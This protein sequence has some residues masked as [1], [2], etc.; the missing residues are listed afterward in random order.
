MIWAVQSPWST[1]PRS[2]WYAVLIVRA[3]SCSPVMR[4][5]SH[6]ASHF[7][8]ASWV[9][10]V[11]SRASSFSTAAMVYTT[12]VLPVVRDDSSHPALL[13]LPMYDVIARPTMARSP[14]YCGTMVEG[15]PCRA[16]MAS[17]SAGVRGRNESRTR[18]VTK[19]PLVNFSAM[20]CSLAPQRARAV[21]LAGHERC[22]GEQG[23]G[24]VGIAP[25]IRRAQGF[26]QILRGFIKEADEEF[27][28]VLG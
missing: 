16:A 10:S 11:R 26:L 23:R 2:S 25:R 17:I 28:G 13:A 27:E 14:A 4:P 19:L 5:V 22:A 15:M 8:V 12:F 9:K 20:L 24:G 18:Y 1:M 6:S 3:T 21:V 7:R